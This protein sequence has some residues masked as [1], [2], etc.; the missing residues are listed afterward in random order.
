M[1]TI[2]HTLLALVLVVLASCSANTYDEIAVV[3]A[4]PTY[5]LNIKPIMSA[6][7]TSCH[8]SDGGQG[9]FLENYEQVKSAVEN[10]GL[11]G[12]IAAPQGQGMPENQRMPQ[13]KIDAINTWAN[14]GFP[15]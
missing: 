10:D 14:N 9:P 15:N 8:S 7:C 12:E 3:T 11:L 13:S 6:N 5:E 1:K 4:T 2:K